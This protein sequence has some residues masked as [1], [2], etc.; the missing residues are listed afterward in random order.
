MS[1]ELSRVFKRGALDDMDCDDIRLEY[2]QWVSYRDQL[3]V[4]FDKL[5]SMLA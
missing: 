1:D 2:G 3:T 4:R 5:D